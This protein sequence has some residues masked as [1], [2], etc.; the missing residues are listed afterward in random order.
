MGIREHLTELEARKEPQIQTRIIKEDIAGRHL[1][2]AQIKEKYKYYVCD[3]CR[4]DIRIEKEWAKRT[5]G[6]FELPH[7]MTKR[8]KIVVALHNICFKKVIKEFEED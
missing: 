1:V 8:G 6:I 7:S 5:G 4:G 2:K 3:Y